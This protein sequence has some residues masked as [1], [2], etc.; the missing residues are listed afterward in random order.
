MKLVPTRLRPAK[1]ARLVRP[2]ATRVFVTRRR[3][4]LL[5][6]FVLAAAFPVGGHLVGLVSGQ[7]TAAAIAEVF[8]DPLA[9]IEGRS[10]GARG[11]GAMFQT[12]PVKER[13]ASRDRAPVGPEGPVERVLPVVRERPSEL[14]PS[15][16]LPPDLP[17]TPRIVSQGPPD[18]LPPEPRLPPSAPTPPDLP[19]VSSTSSSGGGPPPN[20]GGVPEPGTWAMMIL[21]FG[22]IG[23]AVRRQTAAGRA[24]SAKG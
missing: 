2:R 14:V 6:A 24:V 5:S 1:S 7:D 12:K 17:P 13:L 23:S 10:P 3:A 21:G 16:P 9:L 4:V 18:Q 20:P 11:A 19:F 22:L 15:T 8:R